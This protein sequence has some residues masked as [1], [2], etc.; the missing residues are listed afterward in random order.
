MIPYLCRR[1]R[2]D[3]G[4]TMVEYGIMLAFVAS[5]AFLAV[6]ALGVGVFDI[7]ADP[8]LDLP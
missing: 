5:V 1:L 3:D 2:D 8:T 7:F 6:Q 4:A